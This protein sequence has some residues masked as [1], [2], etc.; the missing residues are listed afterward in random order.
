MKRYIIYIAAM[1]A[2]LNLATSCDE[3]S[4]EKQRLSYK[5]RME[6]RRQDSLALKVGVTPTMDCLPIFVAKERGMFDNDSLQVNLRLRNSHLDLDT[7]LAGGYIEGAATERVRASKLEAKGCQ[8]KYVAET[9]LGW[10]FITNKAQRIKKFEQLADKMIAM[11]RFSATDSPADV[12]IAKAKVKEGIYK[13]QINDVK[14]RLKML[15]NNEMDAML[16]PQPQATTALLHNHKE[17]ADSAFSLTHVGVIAFRQKAMEDNR[18]KQ[19]LKSFVKAYN[20]ACDSI[21]KY[22]VGSY[23]DVIKKYTEADNKTIKALPK[24][25]YKHAK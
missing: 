12:A 8:L 14:L 15:L 13:I 10:K 23:A 5:Q 9:N 20:E 3:T 2:M 6:L 24:L 4:Q 17:I 19:Q 21:N 22:G 18:R 1:I 7:L 25:N 11:T 16:L